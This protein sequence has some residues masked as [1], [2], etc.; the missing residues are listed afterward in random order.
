MIFW[1]WQGI[2]ILFKVFQEA[3][4]SF[5]AK[6][7]QAL[8]SVLNDYSDFCQSGIWAVKGQEWKRSH[9]PGDCSGVQGKDDGG[10][11]YLPCEQASLSLG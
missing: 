1:P 3:T 8:I 10:K 2:W 5:Y 4:E 9:Q 11:D 6:E 7:E